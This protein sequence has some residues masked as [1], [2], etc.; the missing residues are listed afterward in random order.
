V[1][2]EQKLQSSPGRGGII[3]REVVIKQ[4]IYVALFEGSAFSHA[5]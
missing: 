5:T 3:S 4:I 2:E 1:G